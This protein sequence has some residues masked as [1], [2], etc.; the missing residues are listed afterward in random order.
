MRKSGRA[1]FLAPAAIAAT[2]LVALGSFSSASF[3]AKAHPRPPSDHDAEELD[4]PGD[5]AEWMHAQRVYPATS[6]PDSVYLTGWE[7]WRAVT[8][9]GPA[10]SGT[11]PFARPAPP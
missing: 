7:E 3:A 6:L 8:Q 5:A 2:V 10:S 1:L 4:R 11:S 9:Q